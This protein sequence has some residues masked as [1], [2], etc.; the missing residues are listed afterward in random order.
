VDNSYAASLRRSGGDDI[1]K[2]RDAAVRKDIVEKG[3]V[4]VLTFDTCPKVHTKRGKEEKDG[5]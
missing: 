4:A 3:D 5:R 1:A 2:A